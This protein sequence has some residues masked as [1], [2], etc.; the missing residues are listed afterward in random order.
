MLASPLT[1][2]L[3]PSRNIR[4]SD[5][6]WSDLVDAWKFGANSEKRGQKCQEGM[7]QTL[8][9]FGELETRAVCSVRAHH[10]SGPNYS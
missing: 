7:K 6:L 9:V 8:G 5:L 3:L 1:P 4:K 2:R 10:R